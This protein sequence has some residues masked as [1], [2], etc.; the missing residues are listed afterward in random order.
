MRMEGYSLFMANGSPHGKNA[1]KNDIYEPTQV[2]ATFQQAVI[3]RFQ[4]NLGNRTYNYSE[5][6]ALS[7]VERGNDEADAVDT[8]F[9]RAVLEWL[10]FEEANWTYN[11]PQTGQ[12]ANRPDYRVN[13][14]T[15]TA[16]IWEDKNST[17]DLENE[18][19]LQMYRYCI[20][21]AGYAV[22]CNMRRILAVRFLPGDSLKYETLADISIE[23]LVGTEQAAQATNLALLR[24]L[25]G[26]DRFTQF[27][28][29][30]DQICVD[31]QDFERD[32]T[33]LDTGEAMQHFIDG[34]RQ[35]LEHLRLAALAQT[36]EAIFLRDQ[37]VQEEDR[38]RREWS[39]ARDELIDKI[40]F[41]PDNQL[42]IL[43]SRVLAEIEQLTPKLGEITMQDI[44]KVK[45]AIEKAVTGG[46]GNCGP[47][48][49]RASID[50][51][52][53]PYI[54]TVRWWGCVFVSQNCLALPRLTMSGASDRAIS[55]T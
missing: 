55:R 47:R 7:S 31:Q 40:R 11:R 41:S 23:K 1:F 45:Q 37:L 5:Y 27:N 18:H 30:I 8:R 4:I 22:W 2:L 28:A 32:A 42:D 46:K 3:D 53:G 25:F 52:R 49:P 38:L 10:G 48:S 17:I 39:I 12:K 21:T 54:S 9:V 16:F 33:H 36:R 51:L 29:L 15:G 6:L 35:T 43:S 24:L 20:G 50:G 34:S 13:T 44:R 19:L 26:K 14:M